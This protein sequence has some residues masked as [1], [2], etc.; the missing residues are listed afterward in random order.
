MKKILCMALM[1]LSSGL[2]HARTVTEIIDSKK[3]I[4]GIAVDNPPLAYRGQTGELMGFDVDMA[5]GLAKSMNVD[6]FLL[7]V[8]KS[9]L[10]DG[11]AADKFDIAMGG[12]TYSTDLVRQFLLSK[13][14]I[15]D[16]T[17]ALK[18][19][20]NPRQIGNV[21]ELN[22]SNTIVMDRD[23]HIMTFAQKYMPTALIY[24]MQYNINPIDLL[25][26]RNIDIVITD[27]IHA[28]YYQ[29]YYPEF[30]CF[31][32][33]APLVGSRTYKAYMTQKNNAQ[34][35]KIINNWLKVSNKQDIAA[36]WHIN[37]SLS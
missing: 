36:K 24:P 8:D 11:L 33:K 37:L 23:D 19:C 18:F 21:T 34:L 6:L 29:H 4:V 12:I 2:V 30:L 26:Q 28:N 13:R 15:P 16:G 25:W 5:R 32:T 35:M 14:V 9:K 31:A 7:V 27:L 1:I 22:N 10:A 20:Q 3:L 17:V